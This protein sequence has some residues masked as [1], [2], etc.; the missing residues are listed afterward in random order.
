MVSTTTLHYPFNRKRWLKI[1]TLHLQ[2]HIYS[3]TTSWVFVGYGIFLIVMTNPRLDCHTVPTFM[4]VKMVSN[5]DDDHHGGVNNDDGYDKYQW[6]RFEPNHNSVQNY[7]VALHI[8][9]ASCCER[10]C[11]RV[12]FTTFVNFGVEHTIGF[13]CLI[14]FSKYLRRFY[15]PHSNS[16]YPKLLYC[17]YCSLLVRAAWVSCQ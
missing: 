1:T 12:L 3:W 14:P 8:A 6:V 16:K 4:T 10:I 7:S 5:N 15:L 9:D 13:V 17:S 11:Q 2:H